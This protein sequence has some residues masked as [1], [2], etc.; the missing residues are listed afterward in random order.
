VASLL[1]LWDVDQTLVYAYGAG[2]TVYQAAFRDLF[3][4]ELP[5]LSI[6]MAGRTDR[7]IALDI[8]TA[9]GIPD[10]REQVAKFQALQSAHAP[11]VAAEI[12]ARGRV[13]PGAIAA[14]AALAA[15]AEGRPGLRVV[16][17]VLTGNVREMAEVKLSALG[18]TDH[19]DLDSGAYGTES[20]IRADLVPV[21]R[22][23]AARRYGEDFSGAATVLV[24]DTPLDVEA[25]LSCGAR[26]LAVAT[27]SFGVAELEEA[28]AHAVMPNLSDTP[29]VVASILG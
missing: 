27:G 25:A 7:A 18:V 15:L 2:L 10:P 13:L 11:T 29:A 23:N 24:G 14:I 26:V 1:V 5:E 12:A 4:R 20:E 8:L 16:Q 28:G 19:L 17:S 21:A 3:G 6:S 22:R 9:A